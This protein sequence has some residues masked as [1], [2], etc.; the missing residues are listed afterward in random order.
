MFIMKRIWFQALITC[1]FLSACSE[2]E[3]LA[4]IHE[5]RWKPFSI[6][7]KYYTVEKGDTLYAIAFKFDKDYRTLAKNNS[8]SAPYD[9]NVGQKIHLVQPQT[10]PFQKTLSTIKKNMFSTFTKAKKQ[11]FNKDKPLA[12]QKKSVQKPVYH[13]SDTSKPWFWP[14]RGSIKS[15]FNPTQRIKGIN[16]AGK[17]GDKIRA[18]QDGVVAYSGNGLNGY[19]NLI[20]IKHNQMFL[21]AYANNAKNLVKE[22]QSVKAGQVIADMGIVNRAYQGLHFEIRKQ[23]QPVNPLNYLEKG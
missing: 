8:L 20:I 17:P 6:H 15:Y 18:T 13:A 11:S 22:G 10:K 16:I 12:K 7:Q 9:L 19:G 23:G 21:S 14:A 2:R 5:L 4:P 3:G 1:L